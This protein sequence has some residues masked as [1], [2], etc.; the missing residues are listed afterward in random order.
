MFFLCIQLTN[1]FETTCKYI[2]TLFANLLECICQSKM[3]SLVNTAALAVQDCCKSKFRKHCTLK[4]AEFV[5]FRGRTF[6][7]EILRIHTSTEATRDSSIPLFAPTR[8]TK[9]G[10]LRLVSGVCQARQHLGASQVCRHAAVCRLRAS[11][12]AL[13]FP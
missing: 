9:S 2:Q 10:E 8:Q 11:Q 6:A 7:P 1:T 12:H 5:L 3:L 4:D 13:V